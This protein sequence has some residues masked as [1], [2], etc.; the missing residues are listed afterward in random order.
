MSP[1]MISPKEG[2][3]DDIAERA[4]LLLQG[5]RGADGTEDGEAADR[6]DSMRRARRRD[7]AE[8][9]RKARRRRREKATSMSEP[10]GD[11]DAIPEEEIAETLASDEGERIPPPKTVVS[12][13]SPEGSESKPIELDD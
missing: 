8:E 3:E 6:R 11:G 7:N 13:P 2:S 10:L 4:A 5:M 9:E 12:P 1:D